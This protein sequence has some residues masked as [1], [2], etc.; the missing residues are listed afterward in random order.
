[1]F[2]DQVPSHSTPDGNAAKPPEAFYTT[3]LFSVMFLACLLC[4]SNANALSPICYHVSQS[5]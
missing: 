2:T 5:S 4:R 3:L 1:M